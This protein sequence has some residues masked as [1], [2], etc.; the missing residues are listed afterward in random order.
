MSKGTPG[1]PNASDFA[2]IKRPSQAPTLHS[3]LKQPTAKSVG[4]L[5]I[6]APRKAPV[7]KNAVKQVTAAFMA[8]VKLKKP[9]QA[10]AIKTR[11]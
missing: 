8:K 3:S 11:S 5:K 1:V 7:T 9:S 2:K 10:P 4:K 6:K